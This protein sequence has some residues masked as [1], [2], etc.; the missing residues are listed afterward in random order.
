MERF[1]LTHSADGIIVIPD[2]YIDC[3]TYP[4]IE[5]K[6]SRLIRNETCVSIN[7]RHVD[8]IDSAGVGF[9]LRVKNLTEM[10]GGRFELLHASSRLRRVF[11]KLQL[12]KILNI[13]DKPE[14]INESQDFEIGSTH[15]VAL[16]C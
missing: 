1:M 10:R 12:I 13:H 9:L 8:Y 7:L 16:A 6:L 2:M 11:K 3:H 15:A 14:Q 5:T 4:K